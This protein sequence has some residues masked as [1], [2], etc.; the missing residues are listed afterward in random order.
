MSTPPDPGRRGPISERAA[1]PSTLEIPSPHLG[2]AWGP[3]RAQDAPALHALLAIIEQTDGVPRLTSLAEVEAWLRLPWLELESD[4]LAGFDHTGA[5]RAYGL[6]DMRPGDVSCTRVT[7]MGGVHPE[8]RGG[9]LGRAVVA[10]TEGRGRQKLAATGATGPARL[11]A[12]VDAN[13]RDYRRLYAAAGFSPIRWYTDMRRDLATPL[14]EVAVPAGLRVVPWTAELDDAVRTCH[15]VVF[16]DHWGSQPHTPESWDGWI[17][18]PHWAPQW[19]VVALDA[20]DEVAGYA[21]SAE[22][23]AELQ[24]FSSGFTEVLGVSREWRRRGLA[25]ALLVGVMAQYRDAGLAY[26]TLDVDA[27][28][29]SGARGFYAGLGYEPIHTRVLY[30][31]EI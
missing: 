28:N 8:W 25:T 18:G 3:L 1:A 5:L 2:L 10:W 9:G 7:L 11:A 16:Q 30:S 24:G 15:N 29:P 21:L 26:A 6:V 17:R 31:V 14:P 4:S 13:A 12:Y 22:H 19:S 27:D 20:S 23:P